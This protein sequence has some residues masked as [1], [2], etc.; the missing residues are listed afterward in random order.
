MLLEFKNESQLNIVMKKIYNVF[1]AALIASAG[2][3][4]GQTQEQ[5]IEALEKQL[6]R[7][8]RRLRRRA[9]RS[10]KSAFPRNEIGRAH[11]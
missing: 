10:V 3:A 8:R 4:L 2:M 1:L 5:R 9:Q 7:R 6:R 11:V